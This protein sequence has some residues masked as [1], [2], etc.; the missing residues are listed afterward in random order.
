MFVHLCHCIV[1]DAI[2]QPSCCLS[3]F[4][5][6]KQYTL[7]FAATE[8][9]S[10]LDSV[11]GNEAQSALRAAAAGCLCACTCHSVLNDLVLLTSDQSKLPRLLVAMSHAHQSLALQL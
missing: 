9:S 6:K 10:D 4:L 11:I 2:C 3:M 5:K 7:L 1:I 8:L